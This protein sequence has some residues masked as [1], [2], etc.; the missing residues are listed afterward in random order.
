MAGPGAARPTCRRYRDLTTGFHGTVYRLADNPVLSLLTQAVTH[1]VTQ[2][3]IMTMD[4]VELRGAIVDEH[5]ELAR[6]IADGDAEAAGRE[7]AAHFQ[8]QHDHFAARS[9]ARL[10][11]NIQWR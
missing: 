2:H 5:A 10:Q 11:E 3:V 6:I 4:P 8:R 9:P 7:M 1:I